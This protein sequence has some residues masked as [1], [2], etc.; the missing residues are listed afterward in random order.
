MRLLLQRLQC[1]IFGHPGV[2]REWEWKANH[3]QWKE[4]EDA[5]TCIRCLSELEQLP[6]GVLSYFVSRPL[7]DRGV[8][9]RI[10]AAIEMYG[11]NAVRVRAGDPKTRQLRPSY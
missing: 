4:R 5:W 6:L 3:P 11:A 7:M 9:D 10:N 8:I 1:K 2:F